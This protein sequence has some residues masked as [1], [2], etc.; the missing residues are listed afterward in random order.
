MDKQKTVTVPKYNSK[1]PYYNSSDDSEFSHEAENRPMT[2]I[3]SEKETSSWLA[4]N[5]V[6]FAKV[7]LTEDE[8]NEAIHEQESAMDTEIK[9]IHKNDAWELT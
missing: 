1:H 7:F 4:D 5:Y 8:P 9:T 3:T 2:D 6:K